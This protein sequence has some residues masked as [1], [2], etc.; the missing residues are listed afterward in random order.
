MTKITSKYILTEAQ[1]RYSEVPAQ[2]IIEKHL[3]GTIWQ[4]ILD[5]FPIIA[6]PYRADTEY[7]LSV[8][9]YS[10]EEI[11]KILS[12]LSTADT[13]NWCQAIRDILWSNRNDHSLDTQHDKNN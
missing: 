12:L 5:N 6:R 4:M 11:K 2:P 8:F 9:V 1:R 13:A 10:E 7:E 3:W